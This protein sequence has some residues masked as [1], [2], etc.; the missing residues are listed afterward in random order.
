MRG[1]ETGLVDQGTRSVV[2]L[3]KAREYLVRRISPQESYEALTAFPRFLEIETVNVC[4]ARCPMCTI[5]DWQRG[6]RPMTDEL[7]QKIAS[8]VIA[9]APE[10]KR[11]SLYRDGEPLI[12]K[13]LAGRV[14][15]LKEGRVNNV[16]ISTNVSLLTETRSRDLLKAGLDI[17][18]MSIDSLKKDVYERIRVRLVFEEVMENAR[19]FIELR[20]QLRPQTKIWMRMIRQ[21][22]N[23]DEWP[24]YERFWRPQLADHDRV[25]FHNIFNWGGQLPGFKPIARSYE[26]GLPC[27]ALW[28]LLVIFSNGDVPLC[29]VDYNNKY[30]TGNVREHSIAE[31]W[32]SKLMQERRQFHLSGQKACISLCEHCNVWDESPDTDPVAP[33]YASDVD[34][35]MS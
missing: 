5:E 34:I 10:I 28:S 32:R 25:Y 11:V 6:G 1:K 29:N 33:Q 24:A 20:N 7:F 15:M 13:K 30:P 27:V 26:P 16:A 35:R 21:E 4:N 17:V 23:Q 12:D 2:E 18:I 31:L 19:R 14:A 3:Q 22:S 8:E 9:H